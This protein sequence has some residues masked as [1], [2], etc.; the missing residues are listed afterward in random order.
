MANRRR[1]EVAIDLGGHRYNLRL[2]LNALAE[3]EAA[4]A[5][6]SLAGLGERLAAGRLRSA[7]LVALLAAAMRGGGACLSDE[8]VGALVEAGDLPNV[9]EAL[10]ALLAL[11]FGDGPPPRP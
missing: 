9:V 11:N 10:A 6:P 1:G 7:D 5:A 4:L 3:I 2:T 8:E